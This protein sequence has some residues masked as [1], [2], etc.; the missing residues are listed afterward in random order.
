MSSISSNIN[1]KDYNVS[2]ND[3]FS[4]DKKIEGNR[5]N[6][7]NKKVLSLS[8]NKTRNAKRAAIQQ[9]ASTTTIKTK[10]PQSV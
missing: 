1:N 6:S 7:N 10:I 8:L 3:S 4:T 2:S 9:E 5:G